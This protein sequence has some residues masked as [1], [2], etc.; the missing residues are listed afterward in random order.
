[1]ARKIAVSTNKGGVLKTSIVTNLAGVLSRKG[2]K[3]LIVD[4][5]NQANADLSFGH[6][7]DEYDVTLYDVL[8]E[9]ADVHSAIYPLHENIDILPSNDDMTF[10]EFDVLTNIKKHPKFFHLLRDKI[11]KIDREYDYC[12][13]DTPPNVGLV[14]GNVLSFT[15]EVLI[16]F[17]P[18]NY[19]MRSLVKILKIINQFK[20]D[21]NPKIKILGVVGTLVDLRTNLHVQIMEE[22]RKYCYNY[23]VPM[24]DTVVPKTI[25]YASSIAYSQKPLTLTEKENDVTKAYYDLEREICFE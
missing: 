17:Q 9:N 25:R 21:H 5:D 13:I 7:P 14:Q 4:M 2:H 22:C 6:N 19:S 15:D 1:M 3:I 18:E 8:L 20:E 10:F 24:M 11:S 12:L 16:P 23:N